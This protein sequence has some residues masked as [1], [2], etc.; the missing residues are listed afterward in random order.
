MTPPH[1]AEVS[2][3]GS[4]IEKTS[5]SFDL[6]D[7]AFS[8]ASEQVISD[9]VDDCDSKCVSAKMSRLMLSLGILLSWGIPTVEN[10]ARDLA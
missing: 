6:A 2:R 9:C 3:R 7:C 10:E 1:V 4:E 8:F 5:C